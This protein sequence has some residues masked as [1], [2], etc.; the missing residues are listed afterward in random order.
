[1]NPKESLRAVDTGSVKAEE[2]AIQ[3]LTMKQQF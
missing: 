2:M 1:M 3:M